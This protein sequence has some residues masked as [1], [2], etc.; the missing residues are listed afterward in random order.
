MSEL[1]RVLVK[2]LSDPAWEPTSHLTAA[3][4]GQF[5]QRIAN[6]AEFPDIAL[7]LFAT[8]CPYQHIE[9][10]EEDD[11]EDENTIRKEKKRKLTRNAQ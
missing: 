9:A 2:S 5:M 8:N 11:D 10:K 3:T 1:E 4:L 6:A 7:K